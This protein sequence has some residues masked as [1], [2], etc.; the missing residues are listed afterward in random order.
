[1]SGFVRRRLISQWRRC[2]SAVVVVVG[3]VVAAVGFRCFACYATWFVLGCSGGGVVS[4]RL[5]RALEVR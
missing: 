1:M 3:V 5:G 2:C 4:E